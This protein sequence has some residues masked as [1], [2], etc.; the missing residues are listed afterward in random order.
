MIYGNPLTLNQGR[1]IV[2]IDP[3]NHNRYTSAPISA[4]DGNAARRTAESRLRRALNLPTSFRIPRE[5]F[6]VERTF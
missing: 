1:F 2:T 3:P 4:T 6:S 5:A